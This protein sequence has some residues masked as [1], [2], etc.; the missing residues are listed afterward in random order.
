MGG[1]APACPDSARP[2]VEAAIAG[3]SPRTAERM[4][5]LMKSLLAENPSMILAGW[6]KRPGWPL[7]GLGRADRWRVDH[8]P[9]RRAPNTRVI[10]P[11]SGR[12][13]KPGA[14]GVHP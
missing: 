1:A 3:T 10:I 11:E 8:G 14:G 6:D 5:V 13:G 9:G 12:L 2:R 7:G 4:I